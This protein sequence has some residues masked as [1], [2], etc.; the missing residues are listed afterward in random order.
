M[1]AEE[2]LSLFLSYWAHTGYILAP[3]PSE[4]WRGYNIFKKKVLLNL[5]LYIMDIP[6]KN[7][8]TVNVELANYIS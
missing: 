8:Y 7:N 4:D 2:K 3:G 1:R 5:P 6:Y